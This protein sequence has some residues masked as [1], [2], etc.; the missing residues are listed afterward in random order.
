MFSLL[1]A[2]LHFLF[3]VSDEPNLHQNGGPLT[4]LELRYPCL[5]FPK[6]ELLEASPAS[7]LDQLLSP[8]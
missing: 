1:I 5:L 4:A 2:V 3:V 6:V 7:C 8:L